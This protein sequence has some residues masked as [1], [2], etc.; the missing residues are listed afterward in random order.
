MQEDT[1]VSGSEFTISKSLKPFENVQIRGEDY[2]R[3]DLILP[4][5]HRLRAQD[6]AAL[7]TFGSVDVQVTR[8][9]AIRVFSTGNELVSHEL[10]DPGPGMIRETNSLALVTAAKKFGFQTEALGIYRDEFEAQRKAIGLALES[11]DVVL[12]SGGSSV[13]ERDYT[14]A[15]I[16][17][18]EGY[19]I[20][21]HGLAI[22][23]GNPT[24]FA[25]TGS[26]YIFGLPGQPVSSLIV[27][28]QFVL[29]FLFH[30]SGER[31][32]YSEFV[33]MKFATQTVRLARSVQP[34]KAKT[35]YLRLRIL[36]EDLADPVTGKSASLS[37]LT[38]ADGF[39][40][41]PP[42]ESIVPEGSFLTMILFP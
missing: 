27:F 42:G 9:P 41:L 16:E 11:A 15:V 10:S 24:I 39:A 26:K 25:S 14:L 20:H 31:I 8:K 2:K 36:D 6:L 28:Y 23:P 35:D 33:K 30:L 38:A 34:L 12:V 32:R 18:L 21:F 17:S 7:A 22:R 3:G 40:I 1:V 29:P 13:G 19:Q 4:A 5:G 37:T